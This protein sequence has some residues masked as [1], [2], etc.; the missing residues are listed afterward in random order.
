MSQSRVKNSLRNSLVGL[1]SYGLISIL[2]FVSR[3]I[4]IRQLG[5][6]YL[7]ISGLYTNILSVLALSDLGV[8]TVMVYSL[9]KP[10]AENDTTRIAGLI[11][12]FKRLY[13][14]VAIVIIILGVA[15]IPLLP[16]VVNDSALTQK[17]LIT[18]YLLTL[19]NSV[20]SYLAISKSTLIR[21]DQHMDII[22]SVQ[23]ATTV[24]MHIFQIII[25]IYTKNYT[26]YLCINIV[27][28]LANNIILT[29]IAD[30]KYPYIKQWHD[31][32]VG[33]EIREDIISNLKATFLYKLGATVINSTDNILIS[34]LL[35]T[36]VVGYYNNYYTIVAMINAV[37][38]VFINSVL[39]SIGNF[40]ATQ[41]CKSKY[42]L[43]SFLLFVFFAIA[44]FSAACYFSIINDFIRVWIGADFILADGFLI[45][46]VA[47]Y[48]VACISNPLW[49]TREASGLFMSVR[50]V[51]ICT[52]AI[53][54]ILSIA[55]GKIYGLAGIILATAIARILTLFWYEPRM[56]CLNIFF[57]TSIAVLEE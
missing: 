42:Q 6:E 23:A 56:L 54:I 44:S 36:V 48:V 40:N 14:I 34:I 45:A 21:A 25:L 20:C 24:G 33:N 7:G 43:F 11:Q 55:L 47:N 5:V 52:A 29:Y 32:T 9:Y 12:Y 16:Y 41:D 15:C 28:T 30:R 13:R 26:I 3:A 18:Y 39:A 46:L 1:I 51:M 27:F 31:T 53:N 19:A 10:I 37:I 22:Q 17:E 38:S 50:Y 35:G 49:M 57:Y 2:T 4:F 8:N